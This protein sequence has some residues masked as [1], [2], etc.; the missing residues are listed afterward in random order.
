MRK[1]QELQRTRNM[2]ELKKREL[3]LR[4]EQESQSQEL[5][6]LE[7]SLKEVSYTEVGQTPL[8]MWKPANTFNKQQ[9]VEPVHN[10]ECGSV[11][12]LFTQ[13]GETCGDGQRNPTSSQVSDWVSIHSQLM[14]Q[15]C[16]TEDVVLNDLQKRVQAIIE[17]KKN[18]RPVWETMKMT[19]RS[20]RKSQ[21]EKPA[22]ATGREVG[23][24]TGVDHLKK[25]QLVN[26]NFGQRSRKT[27]EMEEVDDRSGTG[28][29]NPLNICTGFDFDLKRDS[30]GDNDRHSNLNCGC[31]NASKTKIKSRKFVKVMLTL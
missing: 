18:T 1:E 9:G 28:R 17:Q 2:I 27:T 13:L 3:Q 16:G 22:A 31:G 29:T 11:R 19:T 21:V 24:Q 10:R 14:V 20:M 8:N 5:A 23:R 26:E 7:L 12:A 30:M 6:A 4:R 25:L 15:Q